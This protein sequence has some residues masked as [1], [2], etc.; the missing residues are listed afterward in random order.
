MATRKKIPKVNHKKAAANLLNEACDSLND[1][2]L[3]DIIYSALR[4]LKPQGQS[5]SWIREIGDDKLY[6][7]ID[8]VITDEV[9]SN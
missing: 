5:T 8:R 9:E 6:S 1:Y 2:S 4:K 7:A 3:C